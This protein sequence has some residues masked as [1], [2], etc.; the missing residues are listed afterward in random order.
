M[1]PLLAEVERIK[2]KIENDSDVM[3]RIKMNLVKSEEQLKAEVAKNVTLE[4][5]QRILEET[6]A[7]KEEII[8]VLTSGA[9]RNV[10]CKNRENKLEKHL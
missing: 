2:A 8:R 1:A 10:F 7:S 3:E 4:S 6:L 5:K 9:D